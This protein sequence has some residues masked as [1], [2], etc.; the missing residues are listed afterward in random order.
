VA[1]FELGQ[2]DMQESLIA[3]LKDEDSVVR[4]AAA[5]ELGG[6]GEQFLQ[7]LNEMLSTETEYLVRVNIIGELEE[8]GFNLALPLIR[9]ALEDSNPQV[10]S[11]ACSAIG[12]FE[13]K[14]S[15][16]QILQRL[17]DEEPLV[18]ANAGVAFAI[19]MRPEP[20][21]ALAGLGEDPRILALRK[22]MDAEEP[23]LEAASY[24]ALA[25]LGDV[26]ILPI[27]LEK[28]NAPDSLTIIRTKVAKALKILKPH[29]ARL[30]K[31]TS[32]EGENLQN[33]S[34][35]E[36]VEFEYQVEGNSLLLIF[37]EALID[38]KNPLNQDAPLVLKEFA[39]RIALPALREAL[40]VDDPDLVA[41]TAYV[42]G[43]FKDTDAFKYLIKVF[44]KYGI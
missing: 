37:T 15:I 31:G 4:A 35:L 34:L 2:K 18:R 9:Q 20:K 25:I 14:E 11:A 6:L 33:I 5:R 17:D 12:K 7:A 29:I 16:P 42:L 24:V 1:L 23:V 26:G 10:R 38:S 36:N 30:T 28:I 21:V 3:Y 32:Q 19:L 40:S 41:T 27:L 13:D 8:E 44:D 43:E 22:Q 39:N